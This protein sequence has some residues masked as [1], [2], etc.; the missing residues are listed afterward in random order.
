MSICAFGMW[1]FVH[2]CICH[3]CVC[4]FVQLCICVWHLMWGLVSVLK[5]EIASAWMKPPVCVCVVQE[6]AAKEAAEKEVAEKEA[7]EKVSKWLCPIACWTEKQK[8]LK[9]FYFSITSVRSNQPQC[10]FQCQCQRQCQCQSIPSADC[11][12]CN[13]GAKGERSQSPSKN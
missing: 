4:A 6:A 5:L 1:A 2:L 12:R 7:A 10:Q 9:Q 13:I 11:R 8:N 3:L